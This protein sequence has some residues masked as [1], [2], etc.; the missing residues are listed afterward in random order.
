MALEPFFY[1]LAPSFGLSPLS[2]ILH[3]IDDGTSVVVDQ[4]ENCSTFFDAPCSPTRCIHVTGGL[5]AEA[6][7]RGLVEVLYDRPGLEE[8]G[9]HLPAFWG[10]FSQ[11]EM[12][13]QLTHGVFNRA[14]VARVTRW[15]VERD[16]APAI[17]HR[18]DGLMVERTSVVTLEEQGCSMFL[19]KPFQPRGD[20][21]TAGGE[22]HPGFKPMARSQ[23]VDGMEDQA[24][25]LMI[26]G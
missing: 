25:F 20:L 16:D 21:R 15:T 1:G 7:A 9:L 22:A 13:F 24:D 4:L 14:V 3:A 26:F 12:V 2:V 23:I 8:A 11:A 19:E 17:Q 6:A 5:V 10:R 18:V